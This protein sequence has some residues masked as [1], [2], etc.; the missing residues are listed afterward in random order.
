MKTLFWIV[1][2]LLLAALLFILY[3]A[4]VTNPEVLAELQTAPNGE[5]AQKVMALTFL[6]GKS[7]PVNYL[8]EDMM[9]YVG[10]DFPWWREFADDRAGRPG[11]RVQM[12]IR[13]EILSGHARAITD[14]AKYRDKIFARLRPTAPEWL[15]EWAKGVLIEIQIT[16]K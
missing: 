2:G 8:R 16:E 10:A 9:V 14:N 12:L 7:I 3:F 13:G 6:N 1:S 15:P 4:K 5:R 11:A